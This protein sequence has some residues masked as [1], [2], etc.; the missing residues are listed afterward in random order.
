M[1]EVLK[2]AKLPHVTN[3]ALAYWFI[4]KKL[5]YDDSIQALLDLSALKDFQDLP[6]MVFKARVNS[7][8]SLW[9]L[10][11]EKLTLTVPSGNVPKALCMSG[12]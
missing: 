12:A 5:L 11:A 8:T 10:K 6:I 2:D 1:G 4:E 7:S 9:V 3:K